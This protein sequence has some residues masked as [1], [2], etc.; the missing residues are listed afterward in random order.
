MKLMRDCFK[1]QLIRRLLGG[2]GGA[3]FFGGIFRVRQHHLGVLHV[4]NGLLE[5][6]ADVRLFDLLKHLLRLFQSLRLRLA[7][8]RD[9]GGVV[10]DGQQ[11][12]RKRMR[13]L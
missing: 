7:D 8:R 6:V 4:L 13:Q 12:G 2:D 10:R 1:K 11:R 9:V 3:E 5:R